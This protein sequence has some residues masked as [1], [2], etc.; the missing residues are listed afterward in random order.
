LQVS[1]RLRESD[2]IQ[3]DYYALAHTIESNELQ[4]VEMEYMNDIEVTIGGEG[5]ENDND[6]HIESKLVGGPLFIVNLEPKSD[7]E[8]IVECLAGKM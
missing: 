2:L 5:C 7:Q 4:F 3:K 1:T 8:Q 6:V